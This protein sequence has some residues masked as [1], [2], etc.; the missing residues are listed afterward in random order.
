MS[1]CSLGNNGDYWLVVGNR[2]DQ[3]LFIGK[4]WWFATCLLG[5][6]VINDLVIWKKKTIG[7]SDY[8]CGMTVSSDCL[9]GSNGKS[10]IA[11]LENAAVLE[12]WES[13][14]T[15]LAMQSALGGRNGMTLSFS[16]SLRRYSEWREPVV[17]VCELKRVDSAFLRVC[18]RCVCFMDLGGSMLDFTW[19]VNARRW[20]G[21][22]KS[23]SNSQ[24]SKRQPN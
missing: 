19:Q 12:S 21:I 2:S 7:I 23:S 17:G 10:E 15:K 14:R 11:P 8:S 20:V 4:E 24:R 13:K 9:L 3:Q 5:T 16:V 1:D 18:R 6:M 22:G